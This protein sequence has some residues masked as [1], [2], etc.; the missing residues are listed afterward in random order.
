MDNTFCTKCGSQIG[1]NQ[2]FCAHCGQKVGLNLDSDVSL[3]IAEFNENLGRKKK[4][5]AL[6]VGLG[7]GIPCVIIVISFILFHVL[8]ALSGTY[9]CISSQVKSSYTF[10]KGKYRYKS[11]D[12]R[13]KG[14]YEVNGKKIVLTGDDDDE[15]LYRRKGAYIYA[16]ESCY[17]EKIKSG[18]KIDQT[19]S[20][21]ASTDYEGTLLTVKIKLKLSPD[22]TYKYTSTFSADSYSED[23]QNIKGKYKRESGKL[24]LMPDGEKNA[25]TYLIVDDIVYYSV[26]K[27]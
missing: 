18:D 7:I 27:K 19:L 4:N 8:T 25:H 23:I 6:K 10:E 15:D 3:S 1:E 13:E 20:K 16:E 24:I 9:T 17:D 11:E 5:K 22:G 2:K 14:T 26:Y 21:S 12:A